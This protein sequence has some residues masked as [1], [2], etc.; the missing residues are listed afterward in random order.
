MSNKPDVVAKAIADHIGL[1]DPSDSHITEIHISRAKFIDV[2]TPHLAPLR[3]EAERLEK[4][5]TNY[6]DQ[7]TDCQTKNGWVRTANDKLYKDRADLTDQLA[8]LRTTQAERDKRIAEARKH[9]KKL[10]YTV[11]VQEKD[12]LRTRINDALDA[13]N[14]IN[15]ITGVE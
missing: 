12:W 10:Q 6:R 2:V 11:L 9:L 5:I 15:S 1:T 14:S 3:A 7:I 13:I 4:Q 8:T